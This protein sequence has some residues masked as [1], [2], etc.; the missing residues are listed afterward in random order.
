[1]KIAIKANFKLNKDFMMQIFTVML[2]K[3]LFFNYFFSY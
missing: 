2:F 1:M 3:L